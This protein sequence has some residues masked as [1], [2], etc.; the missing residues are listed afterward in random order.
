MASIG[1]HTHVKYDCRVLS[2]TYYQQCTH[3][4]KNKVVSLLQFFNIYFNPN[5][6][7]ISKP[8]II[9][10]GGRGWG[11]DVG[12]KSHIHI[13]GRDSFKLDANV[14]GEPKCL[15]CLSRIVSFYIAQIYDNLIVVTIPFRSALTSLVLREAHL[16]TVINRKY[17]IIWFLFYWDTAM[18]VVIYSRS[19]I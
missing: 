9:G 10:G 2:L 4:G 16:H 8:Y 3:Y 7:F 11:V 1:L 6:C 17:S 18:C 19:L 12:S 14:F 5:V 15:L 13:H